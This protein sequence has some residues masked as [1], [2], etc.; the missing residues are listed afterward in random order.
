M[1]RNLFLAGTLVVLFAARAFAADAAHDSKAF[2][3]EAEQDSIAEIKV[4]KLALEKSK[5]SAVRNFAQRMITDH[6][7]MNREIQHL[8]QGKGVK[9]PDKPSVAQRAIY[10]TLSATWGGVFDREFMSHNV[11]DHETDVKDFRAQSENGDDPE[12]RKFAATGLKTLETHLR[13]A[14]SVNEKVKK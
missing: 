4:C 13:L 6:S 5:N 1:K 9:M 3:Q 8:A 12:V 11:S 7:R 2:L 10:A 14:K